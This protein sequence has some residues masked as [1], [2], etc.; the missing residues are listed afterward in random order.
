[1]DHI[2][3]LKRSIFLHLNNKFVG[4]TYLL[5]SLLVA[6]LI[7]FEECT[8]AFIPARNFEIMDLVCNYAGIY[9]GG[10][11]SMMLL[12]AAQKQTTINLNEWFANISLPTIFTRS[13]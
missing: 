10:L 8:Q 13:R 12:P 11:L 5:G 9:A 4:Q 6:C 7:T 2:K 3:Q 1:M